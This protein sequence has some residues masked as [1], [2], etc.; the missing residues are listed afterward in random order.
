MRREKRN[1]MNDK[2]TNLTEHPQVKSTGASSRSFRLVGTNHNCIRSPNAAAATRCYVSGEDAD[3]MM[4]GFAGC[5]R[6]T[7]TSGSLI[8]PIV[9]HPEHS[10]MFRSFMQS[11]PSPR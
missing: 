5:F 3:I 9:F 4:L 11:L 7:S 1:F 6:I 2:C 8:L 10:S